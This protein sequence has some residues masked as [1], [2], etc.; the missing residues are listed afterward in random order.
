SIQDILL[1]RDDC[2]VVHN[3]VS[4]PFLTSDSSSTGVDVLWP[5]A[6]GGWRFATAWVHPN[7]L[8]MADCDEVVREE[9][10]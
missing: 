2:L 10:P 8:W 9:T 4:L 3:T 7:D 5:D 1:D 6:T